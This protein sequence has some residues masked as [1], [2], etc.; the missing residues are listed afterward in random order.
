M[1]SRRRPTASGRLSRDKLHGR[2]GHKLGLLKSF[3]AGAVEQHHVALG[4]PNGG[5]LYGSRSMQAKVEPARFASLEQ[6]PLRH[7]EGTGFKLVK[8]AQSFVHIMA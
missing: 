7:P 3:T 8:L 2:S 1:R 5:K 6:D 4:F